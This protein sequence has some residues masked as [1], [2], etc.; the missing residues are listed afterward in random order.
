M[1]TGLT[2]LALGAIIGGA[3]L[4][5]VLMSTTDAGSKLLEQFQPAANILSPIVLILTVGV[6][7][8]QLHH[9]QDQ[10]ELQR[11]VASK[12]AIQALNEVMLDKQQEDFLRFVFPDSTE[13]SDQNPEKPSPR[14]IMMAFS[15]MNSLE[16][17]YLTQREH[18]H[19]SHDDLKSLLRGFT[20]NVREIWEGDKNF[21]TVYHPA[22]QKIVK[23]V[24][25]EK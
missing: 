4:L 15:L 10:N 1:N 7:A 23:E 5:L 17:L 25:D 19:V 8:V 20:T 21:A 2:T 11:N 24:F 9:I 14:Q 3:I 16:M 22:F 18:K 13:G 6:L 12:S